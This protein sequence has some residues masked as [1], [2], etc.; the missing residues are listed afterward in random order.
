MQL[1]LPPGSLPM[2]QEYTMYSYSHTDFGD[3]AAWGQKL[4]MR[5]HRAIFYPLFFTPHT[6]ASAGT[7]HVK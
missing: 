7:M 4:T 3:A 5:L 1:D 6:R 2:V